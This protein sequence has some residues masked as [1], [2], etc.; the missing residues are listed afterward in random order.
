MKHEMTQWNPYGLVWSSL[1]NLLT[2]MMLVRLKVPY[3]GA[4]TLSSNACIFSS[5]EPR[6]GRRCGTKMTLMAITWYLITWNVILLEVH[7]NMK[8]MHEAFKS[9]WTE[10]TTAASSCIHVMKITPVGS[11][12]GCFIE[13]L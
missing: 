8:H 11:C 2:K 12:R 9:F 13:T 4:L 5:R 3:Y 6:E 10:F 1:V 7:N